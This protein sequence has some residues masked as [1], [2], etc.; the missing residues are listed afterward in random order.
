MKQNLNSV[1]HRNTNLNVQ[2]VNWFGEC[3]I[4]PSHALLPFSQSNYPDWRLPPAET[5]LSK[6]WAAGLLSQQN[7]QENPPHHKSFASKRRLLFT[8]AWWLFSYLSIT[9]AHYGP[10]KK[11]HHP[12][13]MIVLQMNPCNVDNPDLFCLLSAAGEPLSWALHHF[14]RCD[15]HHFLK[16]S[17]TQVRTPHSQAVSH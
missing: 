1:S 12:G 6:H 7:T 3:L 15:K 4:R 13:E 11:C 10:L 8:H 14:G 2:H 5:Q 9:F 17:W 16:K